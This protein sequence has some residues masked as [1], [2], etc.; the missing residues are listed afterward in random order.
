[1]HDLA[2]R[3]ATLVTARGRQRAHLYVDGGRIAAITTEGLSARE[4][5]DADGLALLPGMVDGHA[6]FQDPG[7]TTREDFRTGSA[8]AAAGGV[9]TVIEHT[10]SQPVRDLAALR[11]KVAYL[12]GRSLIDFGLA[13]HAWPDRIVEVAPLWAAG[14]TFFK[15]FT[16][17]THGV[18]G[19]DHA[20]LLGLFRELAR[21]GALCLAHCEDEAITA[22]NERALRAGG[23][24]DPLVVRDWRT[25]EAELVAAGSVGLLARITG[26]RVIVAHVSH[27]E[28][29]D[30]LEREVAA[31]ARLALETCPQYLYLREDELRAYSAF[32]K[33]TPPA[34]IRFD[35]D[36]DAMWRRVAQ[37]PIT[38]VSSDHAPATRA[39]K[40]EGS[41]W[42]AHFGLPGVE[43][44]LGLLLNGV[45]EG[46]LG[47]ERVVELVADAPA[48]LYGLWPRKG[49]LEVG[50]DADIAL[51]DLAAERVLRDED[52]VSK[53]GWT[54]YAG[55]RVRGRAV[56][57]FSRGELV[58]RDGR[59]IAE[60]GRGRFVPGPA[61]PE[62]LR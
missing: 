33:F 14:V 32:R 26:A 44:T 20:M 29:A 30:L 59:P 12:R 38:H 43:T 56:M 19:F 16:C 51:V 18:P 23:R 22:A 6:H 48:R 55:R 41:I 25:R 60:P 21:V 5:I 1:L 47:L 42:E 17:T 35:A 61:S 34:R 3:G 28:V 31:G 15:V 53:A 24:T 36:A 4:S 37:G 9:T 13:A 8:A 52:V 7:D 58:A 57:T 10:H 11:E 40:T 45:A 49:S 2:I 27:A 54:P 62:A 46:R 39:Q 50:A